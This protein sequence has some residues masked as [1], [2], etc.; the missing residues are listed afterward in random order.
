MKIWLAGSTQNI[1]RELAI[2][3]KN[4]QRLVSFFYE[5]QV[6][7]SG[8]VS[9]KMKKKKNLP[10]SLFL[11]SGAF[12][13]KRSGGEIDI[14]EYIDFI[15]QYETWFEVYAN[16]DVIGSAEGTWQNQ[17]IMEAAGLNPLPCFHIFENFS[18]LE[19]YVNNYEYI[20]IGGMARRDVTKA[21]MVAFL[22][23]CFSII[24]NKDG[25]PKV[26]VH[27]FGLTGISLLKQYPWYSTDS[28]S[29][30]V[31]S[32]IGQIYVP[33]KK[34]DGSWDYLEDLPQKKTRTIAVSSISPSASMPDAHITTISKQWRRDTMELIEEYGFALGQSGFK[35]VKDGYE[36]KEHERWVAAPGHGNCEDDDLVG[37]GKGHKKGIKHSK[38]YVEIIE[39]PGLCNS[40]IQRDAFNATYFKRLQECFPEWPWAWQ[41]P[42][43]KGFGFI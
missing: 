38:K 32:R 43:M 18:Y 25:I 3:K 17:L 28:S 8:K 7:L 33:Y 41:G 40:Y 21:N 34:S 37:F 39:E 29:W 14:H 16:L 42:S 13:V 5:E 15:K 10:I 19:R 23:D 24:C 35:M 27:G 30:M 6:L 36:L 11:D 31:Q 12:S 2:Q 1:K 4:M 22:D 20:A 26:K 9:R